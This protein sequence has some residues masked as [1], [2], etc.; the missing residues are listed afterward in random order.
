MFRR[1]CCC[2]ISAPW[3]QVNDRLSCSGKVVMVRVIAC[4]TA[5]GPWPA[6]ARTILHA[7]FLTVTCHS[8]Q[9]QQH[10]EPRPL[11]PNRRHD[12]GSTMARSVDEI[13]LIRDTINYYGPCI[14]RI[15]VNSNSSR[16]R[17]KKIRRSGW[18]GSILE[19][20]RL[21]IA[22]AL[23]AFYFLVS[24]LIFGQHEARFEP[25][26]GGIERQGRSA[27]WML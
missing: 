22:A 21:Y 5:S 2:A 27:P 20:P 15:F 8:R 25:E 9:M 24:Q 13:A 1:A 26:E 6:S 16:R 4:H 19:V 17:P 23:D 18:S 11:A 3:S 12:T 7:G 10:G 14:H